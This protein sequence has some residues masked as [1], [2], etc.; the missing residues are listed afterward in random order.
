MIPR[1]GSFKSEI[2]GCSAHKCR[3]LKCSRCNMIG[4]MYS[5]YIKDGKPH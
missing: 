1:S 5:K 4:I 2:R 3:K